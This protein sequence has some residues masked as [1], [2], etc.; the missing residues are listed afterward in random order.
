MTER[1][2]FHSSPTREG[3]SLLIIKCVDFTGRR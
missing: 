1:T 2:R 3:R